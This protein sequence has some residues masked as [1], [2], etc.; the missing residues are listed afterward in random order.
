MIA[1]LHS[2]RVFGFKCFKDELHLEGLGCE[3]GFCSIIGPN[4]CGK[5]VIGEC[6]A[7][8]LGGNRRML[9]AKNGVALVNKERLCNLAATSSAETNVD[10]EVELGI[11][12]L[13]AESGSDK[14]IHIRRALLCGGTRSKTFIRRPSEEGEG[15]AWIP[16]SQA[17]LH[18]TLLAYG[19]NTQAIDRYVVTQQ[20]QA[21]A[22]ADPVALVHHLELLLG[23]A[24]LADAIAAKEAELGAIIV[25]VKR[26]E[27][28]AEILRD[29]RQA[30]AP[31]VDMWQRFQAGQVHLVQRKSA[32]LQTSCS[33]L[34][35]EILQLGNEVQ[36]AE[37][38]TSQ[39]QE[40]LEANK[41]ELQSLQKEEAAA[42]RSL[43]SM[44]DLLAAGLGEVRRCNLEV[45]KLQAQAASC[46]AAEKEHKQA[47]TQL[48]KHLKAAA[49]ASTAAESGLA[50]ASARQQELQ[51]QQV[52]WLGSGFINA[53]LV[54]RVCWIIRHNEGSLAV[55]QKA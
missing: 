11:A 48:A 38:R 10:A 51:A 41:D 33:L 43:G 4:G 30:L 46:Q 15:A 39:L 18:R 50:A 31:Q 44:K 20:R 37:V 14:S 16:V 6:I 21:L 26:L 19:I 5:S 17:E 23:S 35:S 36:D 52:C 12:A 49:A 8:A 1:S 47:S 54:W 29:R 45:T 24:H 3:S 13:D 7:F 27:D 25:R 40:D 53:L 22:V 2:L 55:S 28:E 9:R 34:E 42:H 32:Y